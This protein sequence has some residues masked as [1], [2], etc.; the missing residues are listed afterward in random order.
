LGGPKEKEKEKKENQATLRGGKRYNSEVAIE[1]KTTDTDINTYS[2][3]G[4]ESPSRRHI[5][6][7]I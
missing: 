7:T 3:A 2:S 6:P 1:T 4:I 5:K